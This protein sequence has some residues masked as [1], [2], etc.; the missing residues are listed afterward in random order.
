M[1]CLKQNNSDMKPNFFHR[2]LSSKVLP[3]WTILL[4]DVFIIVIASLLAYALRYDFRSLFLESSS[5]EKTIIWSVVVNLIFFRVFRTYSNVL[6]F[7]SFIDIIR[8]FVALTVSYVLLML[9][10]VL[11]DDN[12]PGMIAPVSV[13]FMAYV[14]SFAMMACSRV[15]VKTFFELINFDGR[16]SVNV[17]I[18]GA[19]EAGVN[20]AKALRVN[21]RNH[22]RLR[23]FIADEPEL[24]GK[25]MMG[26]KVYPND[27]NIIDV[28]NERNTQTLIISPAKMEE[29]KKSDMADRLLANNIKLMTAP[30]LSDWNAQTL[31]KKQLKEIQIEDLLQ[32]D[33]IVI[34]IQKVASHLEGKRVMITGAAGSIGS[35]IM[36]Q[37]ASFNPYK[38][39]L[40]DQ[41][42]TPLHDIRL[43]LQDR[44]RDIDAETIVADISNAPRMEAIF[45]EFRPQYI[46][47]AAAY[48]HVPMMEDNVSEAIQTNVY[49]TRTV[50]DLAVKYGAEKFVMISTD[51]AVNPTNVMGC[52]KRIC[53][54]YVQSLAKKLQKQ[55]GHVTQFITTRFGNVLGS[56]GSVIPRF[57]DQ[58]QRGGPV[59]VTHPEI[60]RYFMTIPEACRLVLEAGSMGNG[61]EIYIF[62]MGRPVKIVDLAKRM[63]SLS[64]RTDVKIEFTGLRHGEKLY[65]EL[66]NVK[67]LTKPT[68]H[69]KIMIATVREYDYDEVK[70]RIQHLIDVSYTYDQMKIVAA[71]KDLVPEFI[72][73]N[74]CFEVLDKK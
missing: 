60:I 53:E 65:E 40:I 44:W 70:D 45:K 3:I 28:L 20:I 72:S 58:I 6:R 32:R 52:S 48:K 17:F 33:P 57:R 34:D 68:Y 1:P 69:E 29:L 47:H 39:I 55:G 56:N 11:V 67:E 21:L 16:H 2:Y 46:F 18:Y 74:S 14:S 64:G 61:G 9:F 5:I 71:M 30:S 35:E 49:G 50:A 51:K 22:Y 66:L 13:L 15:I 41:A 19:K 7:S 31:N 25:V 43:E 36:R 38:L 12:M 24:I 42:E 23:G 4:I 62:D 27:E 10:S 54:I 26:V 59:T 37:V 63:I 73:K 8:I